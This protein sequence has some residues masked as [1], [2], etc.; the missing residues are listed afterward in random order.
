M[1]LDELMKKSMAGAASAEAEAEAY[2]KKAAVEE[3]SKVK[4]EVDLET[5]RKELEANQQ[6]ALAT[7]AFLTKKIDDFI[8]AS[9]GGTPK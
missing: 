7:F 3:A 8:A 5:V 4:K 2:G 1:T 6:G 9:A